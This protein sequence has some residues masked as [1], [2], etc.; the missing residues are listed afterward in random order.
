ME[1]Y[2]V[3]A[4]APGGTTMVASVHATEAEADAEVERQIERRPQWSFAV[5][6]VTEVN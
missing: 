6:L 1:Q 2:A 3:V 5:E 4:I